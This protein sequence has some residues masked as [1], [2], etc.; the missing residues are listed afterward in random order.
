MPTPVDVTTP[1]DRE[2]V[3]KRSFDAPRSLIWD[4]HTKPELMKRWL[5]GP[6]GW[7]MPVCEVDLRVGG[8]YRF[9]WSNGEGHEFGSQ[10]EHLEI[11][12]PERLVTS[13]KT[14]G[15]DGASTNTLVLTEE[16]GKTL[17]TMTMV[18]PTKEVRDAALQ[19]GM[20]D[21][22]AMSYDRLQEIADEKVG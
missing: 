18:F 22:M 11:V 8:A 7:T 19:S 20:A 4:C 5:L 9:R 10:G 15:F 1:S 13:E 17:L 3:V 14:E 21:G 16:D 12:A 6:P 2:I